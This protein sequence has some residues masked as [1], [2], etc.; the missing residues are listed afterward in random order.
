MLYFANVFYRDR[1][2][3]CCSISLTMSSVR[4]HNMAL[5]EP[6][7]SYNATLPIV[8]THFPSK[9]Y[10]I[11]LVHTEMASLWQL[12]CCCAEHSIEHK[13]IQTHKRPHHRHIDMFQCAHVRMRRMFSQFHS[14]PTAYTQTYVFIRRNAMLSRGY[15]QTHIKLYKAFRNCADSEN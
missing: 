2:L 11:V 14:Q 6:A 5:S 13:H 12:R 10:Y 4:S 7:T 1:R 15:Q 8:S 3:S 9:T